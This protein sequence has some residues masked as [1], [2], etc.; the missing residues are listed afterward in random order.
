M[1]D[2]SLPVDTRARCFVYSREAL[3]RVK[4]ESKRK[5]ET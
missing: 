5:S 4:R 3:L 2:S 1:N